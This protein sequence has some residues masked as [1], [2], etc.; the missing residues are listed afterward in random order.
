MNPLHQN[1]LK[2][3]LAINR[4][5]TV[6]QQFCQVHGRTFYEAL[7]KE[8]KAA[9]CSRGDDE[10]TDDDLACLSCN[11]GSCEPAKM[12]KVTAAGTHSN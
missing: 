3:G 7:I 10:W 2:V 1:W 11:E 12:Y 5:T 8:W 9:P 4:T 6:L